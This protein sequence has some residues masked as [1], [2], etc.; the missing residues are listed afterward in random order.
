MQQARFVRLFTDAQGESH[1]EDLAQDLAPV[2]FAPPAAP[3][4]YAHVL[5]AAGTF[6]LGMPV[7]WG[8]EI[9][10]PAP[11]R[12]VFCFV[13]GVVEI[14]ASDGE[15]RRFTTGSVLLMEDTFGKG[16]S[17]HVVGD[18]EVLIFGTALAA[19]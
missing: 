4:N 10:H 6:W 5:P 12:Q 1:F 7:R 13:R 2:N 8:G 3:L 18:D 15:M 14:T 16:H 17:T 9:P 11:Q 19:V